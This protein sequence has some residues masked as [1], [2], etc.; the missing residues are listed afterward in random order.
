V[1]EGLA[2]ARWP[3]RVEVADTSPLLVFDGAHNVDGARRLAAV[4][5]EL[6]PGPWGMVMGVLRDKDA[7]AIVEALAPVAGWMIATAPRVPRAMDPEELA[8]IARAAG[9]VAEVRRDPVQ[10]IEEAKQRAGSDGAVCCTG[11]LYMV[12]E[13]RLTQKT[14]VKSQ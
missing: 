13:G 2:A 12:R 3:G 10:A 7:P 6:H 8:G 11:S 1:Y 14:R 5:R 9:I 4:L